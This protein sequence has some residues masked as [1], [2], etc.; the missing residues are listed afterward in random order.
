MISTLTSVLSLLLSGILLWLGHGLLL[1]YLPIAANANGFSDWQV[2]ITGSFYFLGFVSG[3]LIT[4]RILQRV[5]HIRGYSVLASLYTAIALALQFLPILPAWLLMRF[6]IGAAISGLYM[7]FESWLNERSQHSNRGSV[8]AVYSVL[9][10]LMVAAGQQMLHLPLNDQTLLY[11]FASI[12]LALSIIP[13]SLTQTSAP[14]LLDNISINIKKVWQHSH[15]GLLGALTAGLVTGAYWAMAPVFGKAIG[16]DSSLI[17]WY[18]SASVIG[19]AIFQFPLGRLSDRTDRRVVLQYLSLV[20]A[21][22][23]SGLYFAA[24]YFAQAPWLLVLLAFLWGGST[25]TL[26]AIALAHANDTASSGDFVEI[27]S[28]MLITLGISSASGASLA[29]AIMNVMGSPSLYLYM[30]SVLLIFSIVIHVRRQTHELPETIESHEEF[31]PLPGMTTPA[32]FEIDPRHE[33]PT[34]VLETG[35]QATHG[36][37]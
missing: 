5:G 28:S 6:L 34:E 20:A 23:C 11:T 13:V 19:G 8:L 12:L 10:L 9:N 30:L 36:Q 33:D 1:T 27:S 24:G 22:V 26:Y 17:A 21:L 25:L 35:K 7:V 15:I 31:Q 2:G 32:L 18:M 3:C 4:P 16:M 14:P 29:A 37:H